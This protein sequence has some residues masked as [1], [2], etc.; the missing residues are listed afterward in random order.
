M[1]W[2]KSE[3]DVTAVQAQPQPQAPPAPSPRNQG[4][5]TKEQALIGP[6]IEIKGN[7]VGGEDLFVEGR[8]EGRIEL[9]QHS[10]TVGQSGRIKAD[11][12]G[13]TIVVLGEVDG[14][15][16]GEEQIV[17]RQ[18]ST[19]RGNLLAPRVTLEDGANFKGSIDMSSPAAVQTPDA[20]TVGDEMEST[21]PQIQQ[22]EQSAD[23][24]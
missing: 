10:V 9:R 18:S 12:Y 15:L 1:I 21:A 3:A 11:I 13:R 6:S 5:P 16:Y 7:L 19:V 4:Q 2:K 23:N 17:L 14:N 24:D 22:Q 20:Q 8:I